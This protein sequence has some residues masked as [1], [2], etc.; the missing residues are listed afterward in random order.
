MSRLCEYAALHEEIKAYLDWPAQTLAD[1]LAHPLMADEAFNDLALRIFEFQCRYNS[2]LRFYAQAW[3]KTEPS[4]WRD[5]PALWTT[6]FKR[7]RVAAFPPSETTAFFRTSGTTGLE[8]GIHEFRDLDLYAC[9]ALPFFRVATMP[10]RSRMR[11][12]FLTASA[13]EAP[14][15][16]LVFMLEL[17]RRSLGTRDSRF[18]LHHDKLDEAGAVKM[19]AR[20]CEKHEPIYVLGTA[21]A[22]AYLLQFLESQKLRLALPAGS[23]LME[24]GGFKGRVREIER[25]E[26]YALLE[27]W[28]GVAPTHIVNEYGMT[29]LSSQF[30][31]TTL[32]LALNPTL[33]SHFTA[34]VKVGPPW[35]RV[36][37]VDPMTGR[38]V[39]PGQL[40]LI[41]IYDLAN[42]GS[43]VAIQTEDIG[44]QRHGGFDV[45]GRAVSAPPRGCSLDA[46]NL[47]KGGSNDARLT[48]RE[49]RSSST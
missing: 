46:E 13:N 24:T 42:L 32:A 21:F 6:A 25:E 23:R 38:E 35:T 26:F 28:L 36:L 8:S 30:Y 33:S 34:G 2:F 27:H 14:H 18:F 19:L 20:A 16:S 29:E 39:E 5:I 10:D 40:G 17:V 9:G 48:I 1:Y 45:L 47:F 22:F 44:V 41:R 3:G 31:D 15:S 37:I 43:A 49:N 7:A 4:H 12:A 11:M